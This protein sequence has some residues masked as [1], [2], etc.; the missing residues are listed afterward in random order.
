MTLFQP[1][2]TGSPLRIAIIG[3]GVSG[4]SAAWLLGTRHNVTLYEAADRAGGHANTVTVESGGQS[5]PVDTGFIVFNRVTYPNLTALFEHLQV[6]T[7]L[8]HMSFAA[9][10]DHG[11]MEYAGGSG[12]G[13]LFA[14][15]ANALR[16]RFLSM[17]AGVRKFYRNAAADSAAPGF[18]K[19]SLGE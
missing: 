15:K 6:P 7:Q 10:L 9:S 5:T 2:S 16:P 1:P 4:L 12:L 3:S 19:L 8:T 17:L 13:G 11:G 14:Q 18:E